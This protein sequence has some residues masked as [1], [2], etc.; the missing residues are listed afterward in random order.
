M[1]KPGWTRHPGFANQSK[2]RPMP[3]GI[4][5]LYPVRLKQVKRYED[6]SQRS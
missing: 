5:G 6:V 1:W 3:G 4:V 2:L